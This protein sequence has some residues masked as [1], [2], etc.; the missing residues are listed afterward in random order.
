MNSSTIS[1]V[2]PVYYNEASLE[3]L[4]SEIIKS[5]STDFADYEIILVDDGSQDG[6]WNKIAE[7]N[8]QNPKIRGIKLSRNF[9]QHV[10]TAAGIHKAKND[11][12]C[13]IDA[14]L[15]DPPINIPIFYT[16]AKE[17]YEVIYGITRNKKTSFFRKLLSRG[18]FWAVNKFTGQN[19]DYGLTSFTLMSQ[20]A[21]R[22][23]N[24]FS[25]IYKNHVFVLLWIGFKSAYVYFDRDE[26]DA[27]QSSYNFST[28]LKYALAGI[29]F[30]PAH[31]IQYFVRFGFLIA[32]MSILYS[33]IV[34][35]K[36][37]L[38]SIQPGWTSLAVLVSFFGGLILSSIGI[39]G[40]YV[41]KTFEQVKPRPLYV[42]DLE[43]N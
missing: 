33:I 14:D 6:S 12:V 1:V 37:Y 42:I 43:T 8:R 11:W 34:I 28:L 38:L 41:G 35:L 39:V 23:H 9:G 16:K 10:A 27:G 17:G 25:D 31:F 5:I 24:R 18:F 7:L 29:Y 3:R 30:F 32:L 26:R 21:A 15:Q 22:E 2:S 4:T 36:Y 13:T 40:L 19:L 20:K